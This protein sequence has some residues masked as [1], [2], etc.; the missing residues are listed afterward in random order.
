M[1]YIK[2]DYDLAVKI[3]KSKAA[4]HHCIMYPSNVYYDI[5]FSRNF[6][7]TKYTRVLVGNSASLTNNHLEIF[8]KLKKH[9]NIVVFTPLSY[10]D[11]DYREK[12][13]SEGRKIFKER[14]MPIT[15]FMTSDKYNKFLFSM[16]IAIFN[17]KR[18][19]AMGNTITL[20]GMGKKVFIRDDITTWVFL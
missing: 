12:V 3:Y 5:D 2:G 20:L 6:N 14:F 10:G 11:L 1:T 4:F 8:D 19:E 17:H 7:E 16:D 9:D 15:D 13:I 18:Q